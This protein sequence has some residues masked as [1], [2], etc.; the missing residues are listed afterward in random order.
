MLILL[1]TNDIKKMAFFSELK[2]LVYLVSLHA[3]HCSTGY[4]CERRATTAT[5][6][7]G[8]TGNMCPAGTY[9]PPGT[10]AP[11]PCEDGRLG[12]S[13]QFCVVASLGNCRS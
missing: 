4:Y 1:W 6:T 2:D 12:H 10:A 13:L 5:P 7:D 8:T 9:C 11:L 3:G